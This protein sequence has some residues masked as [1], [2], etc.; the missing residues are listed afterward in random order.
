MAFKMVEELCGDD[1][2]KKKEVFE[3]AQEALNT[4]IVLWDGILEEI[5]NSVLV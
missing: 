5:E 2:V 4:R 3:V 1:S